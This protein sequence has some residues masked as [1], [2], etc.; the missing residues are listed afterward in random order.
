MK[1]AIVQKERMADTRLLLCKWKA[2]R[3]K[4][5]VINWGPL[6]LRCHVSLPQSNTLRQTIHYASGMGTL[7]NQDLLNL[8]FFPDGMLIKWQKFTVSGIFSCAYLVGAFNSE[9]AFFTNSFTSLAVECLC[10]HPPVGENFCTDANHL[11]VGI[12]SIYT[13][14][15]WWVQL[16]KKIYPQ[17]NCAF[18]GKNHL[19]TQERHLLGTKHRKSFTI[20]KELRPGLRKLNSVIELAYLGE[21][22]NVYNVLV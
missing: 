13:S 22:S 6:E 8:L 4:E 14:C 18:G 16:L 9:R 15:I 12:A 20:F 17:Q 19:N 5:T 21:R 11:L 2:E 1:Y 10:P 3:G 7:V